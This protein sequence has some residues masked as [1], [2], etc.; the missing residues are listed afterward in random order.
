[1][2]VLRRIR[3]HPHR[4]IDLFNALGR[5]ARWLRVWL[6]SRAAA[7][8][9]REDMPAKEKEVKIDNAFWLAVVWSFGATTDS[10]G[11]IAMNKFVHSIQSGEKVQECPSRICQSP[12]NGHVPYSR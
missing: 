6:V 1:M 3:L 12:G 2:G 11:R 10:E 9:R 4:N 5:H 7:S 8:A